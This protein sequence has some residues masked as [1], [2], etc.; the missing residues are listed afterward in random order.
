MELG[1]AGPNELK[2]RDIT[3]TFVTKLLCYYFLKN[4]LWFRYFSHTNYIYYYFKIF[5]SNSWSRGNANFSQS[6][7]MVNTECLTQPQPAALC[8]P[9]SPFFQITNCFLLHVIGFLL[10]LIDG[11]K[12]CTTEGGR[13]SR[14]MDR[15]NPPPMCILSLTRVCW[16]KSYLQ[17]EK[18]FFMF[19]WPCILV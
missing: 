9:R 16:E 10:M 12:Y 19:C 5:K 6:R 8:T 18:H 4:L 2:T 13:T 7:E 3:Q 17:T 14:Q 11:N 1:I 15:T